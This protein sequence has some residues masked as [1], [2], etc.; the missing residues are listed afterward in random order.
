MVI[1]SADACEYCV[2]RPC[3]G[4]GGESVDELRVDAYVLE[5]VDERDER[6]VYLS[7][8]ASERPAL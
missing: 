4:V 6:R 1:G 8:S 2:D 3:D 5:P 7:E